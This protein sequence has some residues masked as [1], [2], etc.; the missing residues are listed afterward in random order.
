MIRAFVLIAGLAPMAALAQEAAPDPMAHGSTM[1]MHGEAHAHMGSALGP[2]S[3]AQPGQGAV[4]AI[5]EIVAILAADPDTDWSKVDIDALRQHLV[6]MNA[7]TLEAKVAR[8]AVDG[9]V[10]F[11]VTGEGPVAGSIRRMALAHAAT[12]NG[13]Q[14]WTFAAEPIEGG[15]ALTVHAPA[16]DA[17]KLAGLGFFGVIT[18]GMHHQMHH[19]MI[20]RGKRL[21]E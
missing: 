6:D 8:T 12:M 10:R 1:T 20:A 17:A 16:T 14:G 18:L 9:G 13:W 4:A 2:G 11:D 15:A 19:L 21:P 5:Q 3:P 7:V